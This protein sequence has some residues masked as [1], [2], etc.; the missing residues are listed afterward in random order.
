MKLFLVDVSTPSRE[1]FSYL[2][3]LSTSVFSFVMYSIVEWVGEDPPQVSAVPSNW[4]ETDG[5]GYLWSYW[6]SSSAE[7]SS[8]KQRSQP[9][10]TWKKYRVRLIGT[11][12]K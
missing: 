4:L 2:M 1:S 8:F 11:A 10:S 9:K 12:G 6:P 7:G 5:D 3:V